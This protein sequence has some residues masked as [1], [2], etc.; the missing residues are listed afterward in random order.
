MLKRNIPLN[1]KPELQELIDW[2]ALPLLK[3][4]MSRFWEIKPR[5][6]TH[7]QVK[8]QKKIRTQI[9]RARELGLLPLIK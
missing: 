6:Y 4:F 2:K 8:Y 3:K 5:K 1:L 7:I 9:Q